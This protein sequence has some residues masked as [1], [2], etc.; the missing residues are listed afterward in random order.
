MFGHLEEAARHHRR[1]VL[2]AQQGAKVI[3]VTILQT[4]RRDRAETWAKGVEVVARI[5][6]LIEHLPVGV[7]HRLRP[8]C[9][10]VE[11][12]ERDDAQT[13]RRVRGDA[14]EDVVQSPDAPRQLRL[15][16]YPAA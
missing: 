5:E 2:F 6:K 13:F 4:R 11:V 14:A 10:A 15:G 8:R 1:F 16:Q 12:A 9:D 7:E 3:Y